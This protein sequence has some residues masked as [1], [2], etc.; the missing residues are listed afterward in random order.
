MAASG[1]DNPS[2]GGASAAANALLN[3]SMVEEASAYV[4]DRKV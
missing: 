2:R 3:H 1:R 4:Q